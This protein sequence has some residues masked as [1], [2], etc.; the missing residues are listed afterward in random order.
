MGS[1][2]GTVLFWRGPLRSSAPHAGRV[3]GSRN[4]DARQGLRRSVSHRTTARPESRRPQRRPSP[5]ALSSPR[6][7]RPANRLGQRR[8]QSSPAAWRSAICSASCGHHGRVA[9]RRDVAERAAFG[10]VAQ[11]PAHDLARARLGQVVGPDDALGPRELADLLGDVLADLGLELWVPSRS[12][13]SVTNATIAWPV[14]SSAWPPRRPRRPCGWATIADST[15]AVESRW[16]E[17][18]ITSS[19]RPTIQ[20]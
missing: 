18:L 17:T 6:R 14:S 5:G 12:P 2:P 3:A 1:A 8:R 9:E 11:E 20:R 13:A 16:P 4:D 15:S 7:P 10:D 19:M